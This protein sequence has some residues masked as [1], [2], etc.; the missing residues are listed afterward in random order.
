[1]DPVRIRNEGSSR[2]TVRTVERRRCNRFRSRAGDGQTPMRGMYGT[3][4]SRVAAALPLAAGSE[5]TARGNLHR[6]RSALRIATA[7]VAL[8]AS[9]AVVA[10]EARAR[11]AASEQ[12]TATREASDLSTQGP[13]RNPTSVQAGI[14]ESQRQINDLRSDLLDER[15]RSIDLRQEFNGALLGIVIGI[16]GIWINAKIRWIAVRAGSERQCRRRLVPVRVGVGTTDACRDPAGENFPQPQA[17]FRKDRQSTARLR[18]ASCPHGE[19]RFSSRLLRRR[20][21]C[22]CEAEWIGP[23]RTVR[24]SEGEECGWRAQGLGRRDVGPSARTGDRF[25]HRIG[26]DR[27]FA[28]SP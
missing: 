13:V 17:P 6:S 27:R 23:P 9:I 20:W 24:A 8:G 4:R 21:D 25:R 15:A 3:H 5:A 11:F 2:S 7:T 28:R 10:I 14:V 12:S 19:W 22:S 1:M 26:D 18:F 16:G